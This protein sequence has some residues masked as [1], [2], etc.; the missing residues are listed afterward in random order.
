MSGLISIQCDVKGDL[1]SILKAYDKENIV[2]MKI[3]GVLNDVDLADICNEMSAL[4]YLDI[5]DV[6]IDALPKSCFA[7][8]TN[9]R[10]IILP[11]TLTT[12]PTSC[13][14][15]SNISGEV[16]IPTSCET[17]GEYAF[18]GTTL[19][20]IIIPASCEEI[21]ISAF[22]YCRSL[23][24]V[25][26]ESGSR[27]KIINGDKYG[28]AFT[29]CTALK[30]ITIPASCET[31]G[32]SAFKGCA[33]LE[34]VNFEAGTQLKTIDGGFDGSTED[35]YGSFSDCVKLKSITIPS[36]CEN[37]GPAAFKNCI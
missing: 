11:K 19:K 4:R 2:K 24:R 15:R 5:S 27:L 21:G 29:E 22:S 25:V 1:H 37:I 28:G 9:V 33:A 7:K 3:S 31:I 10:T 20:S 17:I 26:F 6:K 8:S 12:I 23:E 30:S 34:Q 18:S 14:Q 16:V 13:F 32:C 35:C 36:S